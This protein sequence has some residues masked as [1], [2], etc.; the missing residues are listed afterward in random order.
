VELSHPVHPAVPRWPGDPAVEFAAHSEIDRDGYFLR[1][2]SMGEHSGTHLTAP[3]SFH[4][5]GATVDAYSATGL[6]TPAVVVDV[7]EQTS[8][9]ADY[10]LSVSHLLEWEAEHGPVAPGSLVLLC[11]GWS[12]R[13]NDP[14]SYLGQ[15]AGQDGDGTLHF[16]GFGLDAARLLIGERGAAGLGIDAAGI[17]CGADQGY[18]VSKLT[19]S[20]PRIVLENLTNLERLPP[21]DAVVVI[22][23]LRLAGGSGAPVSATAF[24]P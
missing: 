24:L 3:A 2:F 10:G 14:A 21:T 17:D 12:G 7:R 4:R 11:T 5:D 20:E 1:R 13:W 23:V 8:R 19:L 16:P 22:G 15:N 9:D 18:S 6:V